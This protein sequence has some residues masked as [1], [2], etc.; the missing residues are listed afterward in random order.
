MSIDTFKDRQKLETFKNTLRLEA[1]DLQRQRHQPIESL[2]VVLK[3][4]HM[5]A[6]SIQVK[7]L[8]DDHLKLSWFVDGG[9]AMES[10]VL[11]V[12]WGDVLSLRCPECEEFRRR[13]FFTTH[14]DC[15]FDTNWFHCE[16][17]IEQR[18]ERGKSGR[19]PKTQ[20]GKRRVRRAKRAHRGAVTSE[21]VEQYRTRTAAD[22]ALER[23]PQSA[24]DRCV[25]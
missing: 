24:N 1:A 17:C 5:V 21:S 13:L 16:R 11:T 2:R 12:H 4:H 6:G 25:G 14:D 3:R 22:L 9:T 18:L 7:Y 15:R 8:D 23:R 20:R 10:H 19:R